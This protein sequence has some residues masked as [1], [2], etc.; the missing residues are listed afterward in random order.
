MQNRRMMVNGALN[1]VALLLGATLLAACEQK[2]PAETVSQ[3]VVV[4]KPA[5]EPAPKPAPPAAAPQADSNADLARK[6]KAA[7]VADPAVNALE[8]DVVVSDGVATLYGTAASKKLRELAAQVAA[9]VPGVKSVNNKLA[10]AA[11]S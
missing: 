5:P 1:S 3:P 4:S 11:G 6:V 8:I 2:P 10:V 7:L 9:A